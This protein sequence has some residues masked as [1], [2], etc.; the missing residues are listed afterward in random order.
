MIRTVTIL[1]FQYGRAIANF[2]SFLAL[3]TV[4]SSCTSEDH[5]LESPRTVQTIQIDNFPIPVYAT[6]DKQLYHARSLPTSRPDKTAWLKSV[7]QF[8]QA[9]THNGGIAALELAYL[10]L[11][12]DHRLAG[13]DQAQKAIAAL[14]HITREYK[15][16]NDIVSGALWY[17]GWIYTDLLHDTKN[18]I[19]S[20][21][22]ILERPPATL[23][24]PSSTS[25]WPSLATE[26]NRSE[27]NTQEFQYS[28]NDLAR[29][30]IIRYSMDRDQAWQAFSTLSPPADEKPRGYL[31]GKALQLFFKRFKADTQSTARLEVYLNKANIPELIQKDLS[32]YHKPL[33]QA[34]HR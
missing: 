34:V 1:S 10:E 27:I 5:P 24:P 4:L 11:C 26:N 23:L 30:Q 15:T 12:P 7:Q 2:L 29:L 25:R 16:H 3:F 6:G 31:E 32:Q 20:Y 9:D 19:E 21:L 33:P 18:G 14:R 13:V 22:Q 17:I 28:W 8:H